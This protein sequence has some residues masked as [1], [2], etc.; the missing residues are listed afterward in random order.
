MVQQRSDVLVVFGVTGDLAYKMIFPSLYAM[1]KH[2]TLNTPII[3]VAFED[4]TR[5][6][7]IV[8]AKES[9]E[10]H[11]DEFDEAV[12]AALADRLSYVSGD[13]RIQSTFDGLRDALGDHHHPLYYL[14]IPPS[15]FE[16]VVTG[17]QE[18]GIAKD[19]RLMVEKPFGRDLASAKQLNNVLHNVFDED[20]IFRIDHFLGKEAIQNLLYFRFAN[21]FLEPIWNRDHIESVQ[22]TMAEDF[23]IKGRG[24]FYDEV[25]CLRDVIQNHLVNVLLLLTMEPPASGASDDLVDEKVQV[26]KAI[27]PLSDDDVVRGQFAGYSDEHGVNPSSATETFAAVRFRIAT[28]RWSGVPFFIRA[29]KNLPAHATEVIVRFRRPPVTLFDDIANE[30]ANYIRFRLGPDITIGIGARRKAAGEKMRGE[31][32]ELT[33]LDDGIGDMAPYERLIGDA[34]AGDRQLFTRQDAA[35]LAWKI[36]EPVLDKKT[37]P[38]SYKPGTWGPATMAD[39]APPGGWV[40]PD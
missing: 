16:T 2:N 30:A 1:V 12:F 3:G 27:P 9:V 8:R 33:A 32:V 18:A 31:A 21:S 25:G 4:W 6:Q 28:W 34:M 15:L 11:V 17:L 35:E 29:G 14:A 5:D 10:K 37:V 36:V 19:A 13:Y 26:L 23:G 7:L 39:F 20:A 38:L 24:K 22:I 40:D